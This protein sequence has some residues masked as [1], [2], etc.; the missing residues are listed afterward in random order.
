AAQARDALPALLRLVEDRAVSGWLCGALAQA[1]HDIRLAPLLAH[2]LEALC[3]DGQHMLILERVLGIVARAL[4]ENR[5]YIRQKVHEHSPRWLPRAVDEKFYERLMEGVHAILQEIQQEDSEWRQRFQ[6]ATDGLIERLATSAEYEQRL[7][8]LM[9][10]ALGHPLVAEYAGRLW[11]EARQRLLDD[12]KAD[13]SQLAAL[14]ERALGLAARALLRDTP[15]RERLNGWL[16]ATITGVITGRR[17]LIADVV[18]RVIAG[19]DSGTMA[20]KFE[21]QVGA[22]LQYIRINGTLV[23]G[24]AGLALYLLARLA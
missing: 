2:V 19:W 13:D 18:R 24:L 4:D 12:A 21:L 6:A 9:E 8:G 7:H 14:I 5:P 17:A 3:A 22:D 20:A 16:R 10:R 1:R 15:Q 11:Q 23:G